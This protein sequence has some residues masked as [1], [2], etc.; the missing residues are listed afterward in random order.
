LAR[1]AALLNRLR[2]KLSFAVPEVTRTDDAHRVQVR[3]KVVG[4]SGV[5]VEILAVGAEEALGTDRYRADFPVSG[6]GHRLAAD[7]GRPLAE[8]HGAGPVDAA[9][10]L[11]FPEA[12]YVAVLD[13]VEDRLAEYPDLG[14]LRG[15][16]PAL[17][18]WFAGLP[19]DPVLAHR[20]VHA[21]NLAV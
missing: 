15:A 21:H 18:R 4:L 7:T 5:A 6:A 3:R 14:D 10:A 20:D 19:H 12:P 2:S 16:V 1:E 9:R 11:G 17:R 8:L 13:A